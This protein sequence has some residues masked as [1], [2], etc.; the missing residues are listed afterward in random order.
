[1]GRKRTVQRTLSCQTAARC[2]SQWYGV[3]SLSKLQH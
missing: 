2:F 1:M 3:P